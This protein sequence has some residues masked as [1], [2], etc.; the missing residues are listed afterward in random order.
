MA[1]NITALKY[2]RVAIGLHWL[3]AMCVLS[4]IILAWTIDYLDAGEVKTTVTTLHKST[5]ITIFI[6]TTARLLWRLTHRPP[7]LPPSISL[8]QRVAALATHF[9]LYALTFAMPVSGYISVA[10]RARETSFYWIIDVPRWVPLDRA[11]SRSAETAHT[12]GQY[13]LCI[14][15]A[16]HIGAALYHRFLLKDHVFQRMWPARHL[17]ATT[18]QSASN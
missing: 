9:V 7:P 13:I 8:W 14:L 2:G 3:I 1:K 11:L 17:N 4:A 6:L 16:A 18:N 5:G 10:A 12:Y 15:L